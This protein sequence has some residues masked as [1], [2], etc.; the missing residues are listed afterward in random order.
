MSGSIV[1]GQ[2][3]CNAVVQQRTLGY[4]EAEFGPELFDRPAYRFCN[5]CNS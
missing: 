4:Q 3:G 1:G 2:P 5:S